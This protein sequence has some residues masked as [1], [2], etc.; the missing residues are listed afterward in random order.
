MTA[1]SMPFQPRCFYS[2]FPATGGLVLSLPVQAPSIG[3]KAA[4]DDAAGGHGRIPPGL[5]CTQPSFRYVPLINLLSVSFLS[6]MERKTLP[7][8]DSAE[9]I[10]EDHMWYLQGSPSFSKLALVSN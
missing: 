4:D 6:Y 10:S 7:L 9:K 5:L 1:I 3:I 8:K 2:Q